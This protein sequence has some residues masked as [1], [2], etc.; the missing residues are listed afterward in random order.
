MFSMYNRRTTNALDDDDDGWDSTT[1]GTNS[2]SKE[3]QAY[4]ATYCKYHVAGT[5]FPVMN[6]EEENRDDGHCDQCR[7]PAH[8]K[9]YGNAEHCSNQAQPHRI[10]LEC[11]SPTYTK[12]ALYNAEYLPLTM[13]RLGTSQVGRLVRRPGGPP[14]RSNDLPR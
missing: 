7:W 13:G 6:V 1:V 11:R 14:R 8:D 3:S 5:W 4:L 12:H 2:P 9:H 10:E